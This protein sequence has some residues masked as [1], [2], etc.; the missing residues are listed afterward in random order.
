LAPRHAATGS[1]IDTHCHVWRIESL[2]R[3]WR[4]PAKID[5]TFRVGD[6][7]SAATGVPLDGVILIEGG[8]PDEDNR[9]LAAVAAR[10]PKVLGFVTYADPLDP[11]L[12][13]RLDR[14]RDATKFR[15]VRFRLE[16]IHDAGFPATQRFADALGLLR[17]RSLV[18][19]LLIEPRHMRS[20]AR[21]L[22]KIKGVKA[23]IDHLAKPS[24]KAAPGSKLRSQ[25][26][27]GIR[28]LADVPSTF[29]KVSLA[30]RAD[31][32]TKPSAIERLGD[33]RQV[34][35]HMRFALGQFGASRCFWGSD[36]PLSSMVA[37]YGA[38]L[39]TARNSLEPL[40]ARDA[41]DVFHQTARRVYS[42]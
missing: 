37:G 23:V 4:P 2:R 25:W 42:V 28:A 11:R 13:K 6:L 17:E 8:T 5:R 15:G 16:G 38:V 21:A 10:N 31:E 22:A 35:S 7:L 34:R 29:C 1:V 40:N 18:A 33:V 32:L 12:E 26:E 27:D 36:W 24:Y 20:V 9:W 19:E 14:W 3:V 30:L 41:A 39:S